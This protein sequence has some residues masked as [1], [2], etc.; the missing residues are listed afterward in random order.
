MTP[1]ISSLLAS[2]S[3]S[4]KRLNAALLQPPASSHVT[5][6]SAPEIVAQ[7]GKDGARRIRQKT[8]DGMNGW[9]REFR[10]SYLV[11]RWLHIHR[12]V[13]LPL[14]N[15]LRYKV[16]FLCAHTG[17]IW[18]GEVRDIIGYEVKGQARAAGIAKLKMAARLYPWIGFRLV[19][20]RK[21]S[22]WDIQ[23]ILP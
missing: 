2:G 9:E 7:R 12:E 11:P 23:E 17:Q 8:G 22:G 21:G 3:E 16:D 10:E 18:A 20:K 14:A 15:G 6:P 13:S 5:T 19:T 4:F 1:A